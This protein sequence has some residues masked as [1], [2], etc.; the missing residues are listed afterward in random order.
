MQFSLSCHACISNIVCVCVL[1]LC[2]FCHTHEVGVCL[3]AYMC[4]HVCM[5]V[6][7]VC[8]HA[9]KH[10]CVCYSTCIF[11][12]DCVSSLSTLCAWLSVC[13][14]VCVC[15]L[16]ALNFENMY[17]QRMC[18]WPVWVRC[19]KYPFWFIRITVS[20]TFFWSRFWFW[21]VFLFSPCAAVQYQGGTEIPQ[22]AGL[23]QTIL[24]LITFCTIAILSL[25]PWEE[26]GGCNGERV[27]HF[28]LHFEAQNDENKKY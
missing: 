16:Y 14:C 17:S 21:L 4:V 20:L 8:V 7:C 22:K 1:T 15:V 19:S 13:V 24:W 10:A 9:C 6:V 2:V 5:L 28:L 23:P 12:H 27:Q 26:V 3:H 11:A 25:K 18:L